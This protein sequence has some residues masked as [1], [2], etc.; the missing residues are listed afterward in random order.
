MPSSS[1]RAVPRVCA[2]P[3]AVG[4]ALRPQR[5]PRDRAAR[6]GRR[7]RGSR[8]TS[9]AGRRACR[10]GSDRRWHTARVEYHGGRAALVFERAA[11]LDFALQRLAL[12]SERRLDRGF[13]RCELLAL[14][15]A[16]R[17]FVGRRDPWRLFRNP[18]S[19]RPTADR[20]GRRRGRRPVASRR[21]RSGC[22]DCG[23]SIGASARE[24]ALRRVRASTLAAR[25][26]RSCRT[27]LRPRR[28]AARRFPVRRHSGEPKG[29]YPPRRRH[30]RGFQRDG[31]SRYR[32][33]TGKTS[34][35]KRTPEVFRMRVKMPPLF[36]SGVSRRRYVEYGIP[37]MR[38]TR[39]VALVLLLVV[40]A[41]ASWWYFG[42]H[43]NRAG[44]RHHLLHQGRRV[45]ARPVDRVARPGARSPVGR[46][47][48]GRSSGRRAAGRRR[49]RA[50]SARNAR[51][52]GRR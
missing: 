45:D 30:R 22:R 47:L 19:R 16:L 27:R 40:A 35:R 25:S 44:H 42:R 20:V 52:L 43:A 26:D 29:N 24:R 48:R 13:G 2:S 37:N 15:P 17:I 3:R 41:A 21:R 32:F 38:A 28:T 36:A 14:I 9:A 50:L 39:V 33:T 49:C 23:R 5:R 51:A 6:R 11:V 7:R 1:A 8:R 18:E 4:R 31:T 34:L 12:L 46:L 10:R